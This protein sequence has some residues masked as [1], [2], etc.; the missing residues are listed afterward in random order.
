MADF[1]QKSRLLAIDSPLGP[2]TLLLTRLVGEEKVSTLFGFEIEAYSL[3]KDIPP[4]QIVG[5]NVTLKISLTDDNAL[6]QAGSYRYIN[7]YVQ[8]FR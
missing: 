7:G 4:A 6:F 1:S 3:L 2:D 8:S 5:K